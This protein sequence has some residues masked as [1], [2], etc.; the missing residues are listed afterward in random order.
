[1]KKRL[2][3]LGAAAVVALT[4]CATKQVSVAPAAVGPSPGGVAAATGD[5]Q[6]EVYSAFST[7]SAGIDPT[8]RQHSSYYIY[9]ASGQRLRYV[10]NEMGYYSTSPRLVN[11][12]PG[13]YVVKAPAEGALWTKVPVVIKPG[14]ITHVHL[15]GNWQPNAPVAKVVMAPEGYP[16]GWRA[17]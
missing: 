8:W 4:G 12:P 5:G 13:K 7:R 1:M 9:T 15:D 3:I 14:E 6:L 2:I 11:L 16:I 17:N 10:T